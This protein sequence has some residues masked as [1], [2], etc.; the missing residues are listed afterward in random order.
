MSD[1]VA[2]WLETLGLGQYAEAFRKNAIEPEHLRDLNHDTLKEIGVHAVGHRITILKAATELPP[3]SSRYSSTEPR[4]SKVLSSTGDAERR[5]LTVMFCDLV[6]STEL[7]QRLD[8]EELGFIN[9]AFQDSCA[10]AIQRFEGYVARY[11]GDGLLAYFGYPQAHEDDAERSVRAGLSVIGE[12]EKLNNTLELEF[13]TKLQVRVGIATGP[14]VVGDLIGDGPSQESTVVGETPNLAARLQAQASPNTVAVAPST[15]QLLGNLFDYVD[16]GE[17]KLKGVSE[18]I[19]VW[20]VRDEVAV[21]SRCEALHSGTLTPLVGRQQELALLLDRWQQAKEGDGQVV[22]LSGEAGIGKSRVA[23][24]LLEQ[25]TSDEAIRLRYQCSPYHTSSVLH[26][27]IRELEWAAHIERTEQPG[28]K[29][30]K[31]EALLAQSSRNVDE[32]M[33]VFAALL[34]IPTEGRYPTINM[35]PEQQRDKTEDV[36]WADPTSMELLRLMIEEAQDNR[37]LLLITF[38]PEFVVPW[39]G[40]THTTMLTLNRFGKARVAAMVENVTDGKRLP[41]EVREQI[42]ERTDGVPLFVEEL[43]KTV[44]E[45]DL[46]EDRGD[47]YALTGPLPPL[48]I[49]S[50]L[51][52][53]L[54]A[55]LDRLVSVKETAQIAALL[56][57]EFS[58]KLLSRV[59]PLSEDVLI[60][61]LT[62]LSDA[63]LVFAR[64][65]PPNATYSFKHVMVQDAAY[66]SLLKSK[67]R[68]LHASVAAT[69][70]QEDTEPEIL[71]Y[72]YSEAG[73]TEPAVTYWLKA[74]QRAS[75]HSAYLEALTHLQ[76]G[77]GLLK[78]LPESSEKSLRELELQ[79]ALGPALMAIKG[80]AAPEV[81]PVY[82]RAREL[83]QQ[84]G[85]PLQS[86]AATWGLWLHYQQGGQLRRARELTEDVL[87]ITEDQ[88]DKALR[89]QAHHAAWA[90]FHRLGELTTSRDHAEQGTRLYDTKQHVFHIHLYGGH[91][92]GVCAQIH[93]GIV[94]WCLGFPDRA[95]DR[96]LDALA[97]SEQLAHPLSRI[98]ALFGAARVHLFR[99]EYRLARVRA[100]VMI[101]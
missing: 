51:Q 57:R 99:G 21:E 87:T 48:A 86:F 37:V 17:Q 14:V 49:P 19:R 80:Y 8:P 54:M 63:G 47:H 65:T 91:D 74:G 40:Y 70:E 6:G 36:H 33:P 94:L 71:A 93:A 88:D 92:P 38:R 77:L 50:T 83:S 9:R 30:D 76:K 81:E 39:S 66:E 16:C 43:T 89:L 69:L 41:D 60:D 53:S 11:M 95:L 34:S 12:V 20:L 58:Y 35:P 68:E 24:T 82:V 13:H 44:L 18:P 62:Q 73:L 1:V 90:T 75:E 101:S 78:S 29:L 46:I 3:T 15:K 79:L 67:R 64:G 59:S 27:F 42:V 84:V 55:R 72:H 32:V 2:H 45:S 98:D 4:T 22:L 28:V 56:G 23:Q 7:S 85:Q 52:D 10:G 100:I 5:Q 96:E 25:I 31:L 26:P 61:A 97:L